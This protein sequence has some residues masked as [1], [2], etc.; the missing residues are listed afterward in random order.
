[1]TTERPMLEKPVRVFE[2][3]EFDAVVESRSVADALRDNLADAEAQLRL[4]QR[5][6]RRAQRRVRDLTRAVENW[7]AL[8]DDYERIARSTPNDRRN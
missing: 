1:M 6:A 2:M 4:Q 8:I 5:R 3:S 7:H